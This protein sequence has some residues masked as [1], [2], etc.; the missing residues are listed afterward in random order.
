MDN[1]V[2]G[3][4]VHH[5]NSRKNGTIAKIGNGYVEIKCDWSFHNKKGVLIIHH[6]A[7][8]ENVIPA[9]HD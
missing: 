5:T 2:I 6:I 4:R 8:T 3:Q 1:L 7:L 9:S